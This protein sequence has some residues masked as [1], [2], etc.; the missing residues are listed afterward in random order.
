M[1][2]IKLKDKEFVP[3]IKSAEIIQRVRDLAVQ[4]NSDYAGKSPVFLGVLNG[5][6][7]FTAELFKNI[8]L[9]CEISFVKLSSYQGTQSTETVRSLVGL[10]K[11]IKNRDVIIIEDIVDTGH[12]A[13][14][15][16]EEIKKHEPASVKFAT[17]LFKPDALKRKVDLHYI[18]FEIPNDFVVGF[19][20]DYDE[21]GRNL[22]DIYVLK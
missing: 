20:L 4:I 12:T 17:L 6:F 18:G 10:N 1:A 7:L 16:L 5:A 11:E 8:N 19:G 3:Y 14:H 15:L 22:N 9:N 21:L 13:A 2:E